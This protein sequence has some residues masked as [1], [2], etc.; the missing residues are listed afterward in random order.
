[1][2]VRI[3]ND[4]DKSDTSIIECGNVDYPSQITKYF[5]KVLRINPISDD[6]YRKIRS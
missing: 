6:E 5:L 1:M 4:V 3:S 2:I